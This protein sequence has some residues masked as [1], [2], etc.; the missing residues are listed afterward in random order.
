MTLADQSVVTGN[1]LFRWRGFIPLCFIAFLIPAFQGFRYPHDSRH[2]YMVLWGI[3]FCISLIGV[4]LRAYT[5][6][7]AAKGTS[8]R[9]TK[10]GQIAETLNTTGIY[11]I[12]RNPLYLGNFMIMLGQI[13]L[14]RSVWCVLVYVLSFWLY[15]ERIIMAEENFLKQ[16]FGAAYEAYTR[17]T[18]AFVPKL[19]LWKKT[20]LS[21]SP[22]FMIRK[23]CHGLFVMMIIFSVLGMACDA[24]AN[25]SFVLVNVWVWI[26]GI[27]TLVYVLI[28]LVTKKI[29]HDV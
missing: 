27:S 11:S 5:V 25:G 24:V 3:C 21:Y 1:L 8:G 22:K 12:V 29:L 26:A 17:L 14:L 16:K 7:Y 18:P 6:G 19:S 13:M 28:N 9:N 4:V 20:V 23:E 2:A 10:E 15:Y